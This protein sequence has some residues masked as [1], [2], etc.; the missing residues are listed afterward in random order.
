[1][2]NH[3]LIK[4]FLELSH[5]IQKTIHQACIQL[6]IDKKNPH[7]EDD[8]PDYL[9][10]LTKIRCDTV[11]LFMDGVIE[12]D[13]AYRLDRPPSEGIPEFS[14]EELDAVVVLADKLGMQ[15]AAHCIGNG[16]VKSML[17]A[18][19]KARTEHGKIDEARGHQIPHRIEH[20]EICREEDERRFGDGLLVAS[21]QPHE[22]PP[23][24]IWHEMVPKKEW[25]TAFSWKG[26]LDNGAV[27][28]FGSD[29]PIVSCD[30]RTG[31]RHATT[32]QPW[33]D[34]AR[35]QQLTLQQALAAYTSNAC[36]PEYSTQIKGKIQPGMLAD[37]VILAG[38]VHD[39][40]ENTRP[41]PDIG[42]TIC[43]GTVTYDQLT[44]Q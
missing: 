30:I 23:M 13:T 35:E 26:V 11:K 2:K 4:H 24:T 17:D 33:F 5:H 15:V 20:I 29:W 21:M 27:L 41:M 32:R 8:M 44:C 38:D 39:L 10:E 9:S 42:M 34:G 31:I 22:S 16:S 36:V 6:H 7:L 19:A 25:N 28:V 3:P 43:N 37:I 40:C 14:Q 18:V 1:A 12:K